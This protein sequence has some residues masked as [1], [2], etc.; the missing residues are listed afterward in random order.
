MVVLIA[1]ATTLSAHETRPSIADVTVTPTTVEVTIDTSI[2]AILA[3]ID[4]SKYQDTNDAPER[5]A[6]DALRALSDDA[7]RT[8]VQQ[9]SQTIKGGLLSD[10]SLTFELTKIEVI[11]EPDLE[12]PRDTKVTFLAPLPEGDDPIRLGLSPEFGSVVVRHSEDVDAYAA[13]LQNGALSAELP[14]EG[15]VE[16]TA[17]GV[18]WRYVV[19]GFEHIIP[20]GLDHILFVLGLFLFS[21]AWRPLL[22]QVTAFTLAHTVTLA[23]ASIGTI[24]IPPTSMWIVEA[25]IALSITYVAVE[26]ILRPQLG[27][28]RIVVVFGFGLLHGLGFAS[29]LG[30]FGLDSGQFILSLIAFNIGVEIGQLAVI[31]IAFV[32][33]GLTLGKSPHYR[34]IVVIPGSLAIAAVGLYWVVERTIL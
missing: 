30:E 26:N 34:R 6:Y 20:M 31:A 14:R 27:W 32:L 24:T 17:L 19:S 29:V 8:E 4:L 5:A 16:E 15:K 3:G 33:L 22:S 9:G 25:L 28:W 18:F 13:F 1:F 23:L 2:E 7:L 12:L 10:P 11:A 21:L